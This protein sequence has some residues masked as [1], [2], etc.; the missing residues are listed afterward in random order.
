MKVQYQVASS[1]REEGKGREK[2][3]GE[4][5]AQDGNGKKSACELRNTREKDENVNNWLRERERER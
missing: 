2:R 3:E 5:S 1:L 4:G